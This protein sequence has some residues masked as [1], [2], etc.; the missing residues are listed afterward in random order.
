[1]GKFTGHSIT[2]DSALGSAVI[3]RS[4]RFNRGDEA[5]LEATLGLGSPYTWTLSI[6]V[7]KAVN[8]EHQAILASGDSS[9]YLSL[10]HIS[11]PTRPY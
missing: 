10:I 1:M 7:K 9:V 6:W 11:E 8:G 5:Y 2:S 3:Q 4:L